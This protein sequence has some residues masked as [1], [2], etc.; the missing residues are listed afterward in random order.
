MAEQRPKNTRAK[1]N[2]MPPSQKTLRS[3]EMSRLKTRI[4]QLAEELKNTKQ[5]SKFVYNHIK[6]RAAS[7][8]P[9]QH[10][11]HLA[12]YEEQ[13]NHIKDD[14]VAF[15]K[16]KKAFLG[17]KPMMVNVLFK[18][19]VFAEK[20]NVRFGP[21]KHKT[22]NRVLS[23]HEYISDFRD[24]VF[25]AEK[26]WRNV[27][28]PR[29]FFNAQNKEEVTIE[30]A[31]I[32]TNKIRRVTEFLS[33]LDKIQP[34][35]DIF[36]SSIY[37]I[38]ESKDVY[39][40]ID[41]IEDIPRFEGMTPEPTEE[42]LRNQADSKVKRMASTFLVY[43]INE[44]A[45]KFG[46]LI[47]RT[48]EHVGSLS[49]FPDAIL[50]TWA[51]TYSTYYKKKQLNK[52]VLWEI[53]HGDVPYNESDPFPLSWTQAEKVFEYLGV[54]V[55]MV[56][57]DG[58]VEA[59]YAPTKQ[60]THL[61]RTLCIMR[62][63]GHAYEIAST[64]VKTS[65]SLKEFTQSMNVLKT[66]NKYNQISGQVN[67]IGVISSID[68]MVK[69]V[70]AV[71]R[72][73]QKK[74]KQLR[75]G[76]I[77]VRFI[78][79]C[80]DLKVVLRHLIFN[81]NY[82]PHISMDGCEV[83]QIVIKVENISIYLSAIK[84]SMDTIKTDDFINM[85]DEE[86]KRYQDV[87]Q[88]FLSK[89]TAPK[90]KS[91]YT[92]QFHKMLTTYTRAAITKALEKFDGECVGLDMVKCYPFLLLIL[93]YLPV[94]NDDFVKYDGHDITREEKYTM[95]YVERLNTPTN[96]NEHILMDKK[97]DVVFG[98]TL[99]K[100]LKTTLKVR[101]K[102]FVRPYKLVPNF[103]RE[104]IQRVAK[105]DLLNEKVMKQILLEGLGM[106]GKLYNGK[107]RSSIHETLQ[108]AHVYA[109]S[110]N[111]DVSRLGFG[112]IEPQADDIIRYEKSLYIVTQKSVSVLSEGYKAIQHLIYDLCR[113]KLS[114]IAVD[115]EKKGCTVR[116]IKTDCLV[117]SNEDAEKLDYPW[118]EDIN[119]KD[120]KNFG[121]V[122]KEAVGVFP[123]YKEEQVNGVR[124]TKA[125]PSPTKP[126][127][128]TMK[129]EYDMME[130]FDK[131]DENKNIHIGADHAGSG[132][133]LIGLSYIVEKYLKPIIAS[134]SGADKKAIKKEFKAKHMIACPQNAQACDI[135]SKKI[136]EFN[137]KG[138][139][140]CTLYV[141]CDARLNDD[142]SVEQCGGRSDSYDIVLLEEVG[143]YTVQEWNMLREY[144]KA[145]PDT[146]FIS[147][148]DINQCAP[149]EEDF[150]K[151][152]NAKTYYQQII[153]NMFPNQIFLKEP[154]RY[155]SPELKKKAIELH[156]DIFI[157]NMNIQSVLKKYAKPMTL[158]KIPKDALIITYLQDTR[159]KMNKFM[160]EKLH[161]NSKYYVGLELKANTRIN[162][163]IDDTGGE[164][165]KIQKNFIC[166]I[167]EIN[168]NNLI[169]LEP[170]SKLKLILPS[171]NYNN[172]SL[173][174]ANTGHSQQGRSVDKPVVIFDST[175]KHVTK[176]WLYVALTRNR[177][178]EVYYHNGETANSTMEQGYLRM[179]IDGYKRQDIEAN[180]KFDDE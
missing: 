11:K 66:S 122:K 68:E 93:E 128:Y 51:A 121:R 59:E 125:F 65:L 144:I 138:F 42:Q 141:L 101:V 112:R 175:F 45:D 164:R 171:I 18:V 41:A 17:Y 1:N 76:D 110:V 142:G 36:T 54:A 61:R 14:R 119:G 2:A 177:N 74:K 86:A 83:D 81:E 98:F 159:H 91:K 70:V 85:S 26:R 137:A 88:R 111:G 31:G 29:P 92:P 135:M 64:D 40:V 3:Q 82:I 33:D 27:I 5:V 169:I 9:N 30:T 60:N 28:M 178:L 73:Q 116:A 78:W 126:N 38:M 63:D 149:V 179:K 124:W 75:D 176:E 170:L 7:F 99:R 39:L 148:G 84:V 95:Y 118:K 6:K 71:H 87:K 152:V 8:K 104:E 150:N 46:D 168:E 109:K 49:C 15:A 129:N 102:S 22:Q 90:H 157:N 115:V 167:L 23:A 4:A 155:S 62:K 34:S 131:I 173:P 132:K 53:V 44:L 57:K 96:A 158:N 25:V 161:P 100:I 113:Y 48:E 114:S 162:L 106:L 97:Y 139:N 43:N 174:Y 77:A 50:N 13:A 10:I 160:Q 146:K 21:I 154:K 37:R 67:V 47:K 140:A 19:F 108:D 180:I 130:A 69:H 56:N 153:D 55:K 35:A 136:E 145:H 120:I 52:K 103:M 127:V 147:N 134:D 94:F 89:I 72:E 58:I 151:Y 79:N 172:F 156:A 133:S 143:Q 32:I 20:K 16:T 107:T 163:V 117:V 166:K 12:K 165:F 80:E 105:D 24:G 123:K